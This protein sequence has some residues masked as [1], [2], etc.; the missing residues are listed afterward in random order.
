MN[1]HRAARETAWTNAEVLWE[2]RSASALHE[3]WL[4]GITSV[5]GKGLLVAVP[6]V[7]TAGL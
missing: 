6:M 4:D 3:R 2:L 5:A 7:Q 1:E